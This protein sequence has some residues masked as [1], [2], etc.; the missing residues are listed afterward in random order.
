MLN[1]YRLPLDFVL[2]L[3]VCCRVSFVF[4]E[5]LPAQDLLDLVV[6]LK[7]G[8]VGLV[9]AS[10][11]GLVFLVIIQVNVRICILI[12]LHNW[13]GGI[14]VHNASW[15]PFLSLRALVILML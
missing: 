8:V 4:R 5:A 9:S 1:D 2:C 12:L 10:R 6:I 13:R 11:V 15:V 14:K 7:D 3:S